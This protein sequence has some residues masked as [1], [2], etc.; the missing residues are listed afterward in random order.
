M[1]FFLF[2]RANNV[3]LLRYSSAILAH[4][5]ERTIYLYVCMPP[6]CSRS[7]WHCHGTA[8]ATHSDELISLSC[9]SAILH[10]L[11]KSLTVRV[12]TKSYLFSLNLD[13]MRN[14]KKASCSRPV[15]IRHLDH[16]NVH[17]VDALKSQP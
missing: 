17:S 10:C 2:L 4:P 16:S 14:L 15:M 5:D 7:F 13:L 9:I 6:S 3:I 12:F 11:L 1:Y 8:A